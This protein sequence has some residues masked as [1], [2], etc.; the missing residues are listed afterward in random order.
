MAAGLIRTIHHIDHVV[1]E[2]KINLLYSQALS[3][4]NGYSSFTYRVG[5]DGT[6]VEISGMA[7]T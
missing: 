1:G 7:A 3:V 6:D 5:E 2:G 4:K